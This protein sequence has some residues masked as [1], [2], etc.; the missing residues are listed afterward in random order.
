[1]EGI[2]MTTIYVSDK[3]TLPKRED[4]DFYPTPSP[5]VE[6]CLSVLPT[7][8]TPRRI[9]DPGS[10]T[11]VWGDAARK[12]WRDAWILGAEIRDIRKPDSY[13]EMMRGDFRLQDVPCQVDLVMGN[14]P[15]KYAESFVRIG[16]ETLRPNGFL[17]YL[18]RLNFLEG[19]ARAKGLYR[20]FP[21]YECHVL[22]RVSFTGNGKVNATAFGLFVWK[23][24]HKG[25]TALKW[26][27]E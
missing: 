22:G 20:K 18:L 21:L 4:Y 1:M 8:F 5:V 25:D 23:Q 24:G 12:R 9:L 2:E 19:K 11:G 15:Y 7:D 10:G 3:S 14:P 13:D 26:S 16:L 17:V 6:R 27:L